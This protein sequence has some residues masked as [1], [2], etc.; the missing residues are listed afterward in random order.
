MSLSTAHLQPELDFRSFISSLKLDHFNY[1]EFLIAVGRTQNGVT[2]TF[3]PRDLW[4]NIGPTAIVLDALRDV[5]Q[6]PI[7]IHSCYRSKPYNAEIGGASRSQHMR[8][9]AA[10]ISSPYADPD[11]IAETL[12]SFQ[13]STFEVPFDVSHLQYEGLCFRFEGGIGLYNNF[14]HVDTRGRNLYW[15]A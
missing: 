13:N 6:V 3:P 4:L 11:I 1:R 12:R 10:D 8:F 15:H 7:T 9:T 14:V 2:N 5:L